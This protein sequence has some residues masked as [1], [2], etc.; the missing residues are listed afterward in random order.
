[1]GDEIIVSILMTGSIR[2]MQFPNM[3]SDRDKRQQESIV[4]HVMSVLFFQ[5]TL[6]PARIQ[7]IDEKMSKTLK[8]IRWQRIM[9]KSLEQRGQYYFLTDYPVK[10]FA[11][12]NL[13]LVFSASFMLMRTF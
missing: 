11:N 13:H 1:M 5:E 12:I 10:T 4:H 6:R 8:K 9:Q 2:K 7:N 3:L